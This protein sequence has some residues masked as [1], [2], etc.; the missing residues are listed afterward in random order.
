MWIN[1]NLMWVKTWFNNCHQAGMINLT[2]YTKSWKSKFIVYLVIYLAL[3]GFSY[4]SH[5]FLGRSNMH[6]C[7]NWLHCLWNNRPLLKILTGQLTSLHLLWCLDS[8]PKIAFSVEFFFLFLFGKLNFLNFFWKLKIIKCGG[9]FISIYCSYWRNK[10]ILG[11]TEY[12]KS[13][14][15]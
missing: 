5:L 4:S 11:M 13:R 9:H 1:I 8:L 6:P 3:C 15:L 7:P 10:R 12:V 14:I 2:F